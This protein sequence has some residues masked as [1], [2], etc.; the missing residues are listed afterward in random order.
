MKHY[1]TKYRDENGNRKA[2]SWL[3]VNLFGKAYC[4]NQKTIDV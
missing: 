2:V 3:Q 1:I 4:F